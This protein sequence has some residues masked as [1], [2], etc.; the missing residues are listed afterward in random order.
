[1]NPIATGERPTG[2]RAPATST[3]GSGAPG[4]CGRP[5][6]RPANGPSFVAAA[7]RMALAATG[8]LAL[9]ACLH[10]MG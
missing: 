5:P 6:G 8:S 10:C 3:P 7:L 2:P 4:S 9:S 1:M